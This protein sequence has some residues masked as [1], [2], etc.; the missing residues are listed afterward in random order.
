MTY[1]LLI[2]GGTVVD[3]SQGLN[4]VRDVALAGGNVAAVEES[5]PENDA[6]EHVDASGLIVTPGLM[7][8]HVHNYWG[9]THY[10]IEPD[11]TNITKGVTTALDAGSAGAKTFPAFRRH[12]LER[13]DTRLLALL[14]ISALGMISPKIGEL[15][16]LALADV[17]LAVRTGRENRDFVLGIKARL[18][19]AIAGDHDVEALKRALEAAEAI[20]G[21]VMIHVGIT[22]TPM[23]DLTAMLRPGDAVTH[24]FHGNSHGI[25]DD[26]GRVIDGIVESQKRG[27][28]FDIG[29]G[30][31]S[32]SFDVAEKAL[33]QG[34]YPGNISSDLHAYNIE[35]PVHDQ[36]T[37]LSKFLHLGLSLDNVIRLSTET[38]ART[39]GL[40]N[41]LGTL[42]V[43][44]EGD[45]TILRLDE[46]RFALTDSYG[47]TVEAR[48]KLGHVNTVKGGRLYRPWLGVS[49]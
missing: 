8:L 17:E 27:I 10:G 11:P 22:K 44:A 9:V 4:G 39:M 48:Q 46:G 36:V 5:I 42:K 13:S 41:K 19:K 32:F 14:N 47:A 37:T 7:D 24:S 33:A 2:K 18:S 40:A 31:G 30:A 16:E 38:T 12:V 45:V 34:F 20:D 1:D 29:H 26:A 43:G 25:L 3:P 15:D 21:F 28:I 6:L 23:E 35:G 49:D